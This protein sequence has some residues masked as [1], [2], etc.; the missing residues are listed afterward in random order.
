MKLLCPT[1]IAAWTVAFLA[2]GTPQAQ[3]TKP[4]GWELGEANE[5]RIGA[6]SADIARVG[7]HPWAGQY[8]TGDGLGVNQ[9]LY[10]A[11]ETGFVYVWTGCLGIY[12]FNHGSVEQRDDGVLV[13]QPKLENTG[14]LGVPTKLCPVKWGR[15]SYLVPE[16][17]LLDFASAVNSGAAA[18][19]YH[20]P[21]FLLRL[22]DGQNPREPLPPEQGLPTGPKLL[23]DKLLK[24]PLKVT[25]TPAGDRR[26]VEGALHSFEMP[27]TIAAGADQG[28]FVGM[29]L[30]PTTGDMLDV[31]EVTEVR[32]DSAS[33]IL[34]QYVLTGEQVPSPEKVAEASSRSRLH[35]VE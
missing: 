13:L 1:L 9:S 26:Q 22:N 19:K 29:R 31:V 34:R 4:S 23:M 5:A 24:R 18:Q 6:I 17:K 3:D 21:F 20:Q 11:P 16:S 7:D 15:R 8:Y 32:P 12:D 2:S 30:F 28:V 10:L 33:G 27:V 25:I 14:R 35:E